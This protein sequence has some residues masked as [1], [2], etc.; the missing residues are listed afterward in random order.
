MVLELIDTCYLWALSDQLSDMLFIFVSLVT[1][2]QHS[3]G[4]VINAKTPRGTKLEIFHVFD[5][6]HT[7]GHPGIPTT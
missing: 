6:A 2:S 4:N 7:E 5:V 1:P 3:N